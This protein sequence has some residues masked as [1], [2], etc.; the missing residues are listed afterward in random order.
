[1]NNT[2]C[3]PAWRSGH[4]GHILVNVD[5]EVPMLNKTIKMMLSIIFIYTSIPTVTYIQIQ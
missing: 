5:L 4:T 1:M 3:V 2:M